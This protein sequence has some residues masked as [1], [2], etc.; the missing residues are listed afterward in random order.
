RLEGELDRQALESALRDVVGRHESLRTVFPAVDGEP[1]QQVLPDG[2]ARVSVTW[3]TVSAAEAA[4]LVPLA[5]RH[6]FSLADEIPGAAEVVSTGPREH[7]L[8]LVMH[9]IACDGLSLSPLA[10]DLAAAYSARVAGSAPGWAD[11]PVQYADFTL[12]QHA[13]LGRED[14][15][16]SVM[17]QQV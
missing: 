15:P 5:C 17:A 8:V 14:D 3:Q 1:F 11:L 7:V 16:G 13:M 4:R 10:R 2:D 12:W 9:P 6:E